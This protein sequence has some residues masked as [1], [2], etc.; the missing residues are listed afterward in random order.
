MQPAQAAAPQNI[1]FARP[2]FF[3][4]ELVF[5][6]YGI[7]G[8]PRGCS[9][10]PHPLRTNR[11]RWRE[12]AGV[13]SCQKWENEGFLQEMTP[14]WPI[15]AILAKGRLRAVTKSS[16]AQKPITNFFLTHACFS[17]SN[18]LKPL[19]GRCASKTR[20]RATSNPPKVPR[21]AQNREFSC[22]SAISGDFEG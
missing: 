12:W 4:P 20:I 10:R 9:Q 19:P 3:H 5:W 13:Q 11:A 8:H 18:T 21:N 15:S 1:D 2:R 7:C 6:R 16:S 17:P 22:F 14:K